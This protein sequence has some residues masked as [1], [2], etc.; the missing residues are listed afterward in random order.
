[1]KG[2]SDQELK[3]LIISVGTHQQERRLSPLEVAKILEK[4][5][6]AGASRRECAEA[7]GLG[8]TYVG[9]FLR[10][11][12]LSPE[13]QHLAKWG[14]AKGVGIAFSAMAWLTRLAPE[15]QFYA[16]EAILKHDL[17]WKEVVELV[18]L[19]SRSYKTI[20]KCVEAVL[21]RRPIIET[22]H[23]LVGAITSESV[24][25]RLGNLIQSQR[26]EL[27]NSV[28]V[29]LLGME[30]GVTGRLGISRFS[31]IGDVDPAKLVEL[32]PNE[33]ERIVNTT[34]TAHIEG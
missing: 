28:L 5:I 12:N 19:A 34:L 13:I 33:F 23:L 21:Q 9:Y 24:R 26:D 25:S 22:R 14:H 20:E 6:K 29:N 8:T 4:S 2:L 7:I 16:A 11:L 32:S 18:Q 31:V 15:D 30:K 10:L 1:M 27:F 17:T 3:E